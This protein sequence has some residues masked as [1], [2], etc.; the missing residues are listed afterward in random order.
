MVSPWWITPPRLHGAYVNYYYVLQIQESGG[1]IR[2]VLLSE[3]AIPGRARGELVG[4][5]TMPYLNIWDFASGMLKVA[6]AR[7]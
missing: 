5:L 4:W 7:A 1:V 6:H 2:R 3:C